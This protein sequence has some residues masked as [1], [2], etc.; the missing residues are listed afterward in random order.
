MRRGTRMRGPDDFGGFCRMKNRQGM[1]RAA[2]LVF[3]GAL[4]AA[5][6]AG[7]GARKAAAQTDTT[8]TAKV[9]RGDLS[10]TVHGT[11]ALAPTSVQAVS[12]DS[13]GKVTQIFKRNGD[14][15]KNGDAIAEVT[16][17]VTDEKKNITAPM[18]GVVALSQ[19]VVGTAVQAGM[20]VCQVQSTGS[21]ELTVG[22]DELDISGVKTGQKAD[23]KVDALPGKTFSGTVNRISQVGVAA[24]GVTTFDVTIGLSDSAGMLSNMSASA[25]IHTG[26]V[27]NVLLVPVE[28]LQKADNGYTLTVRTKENDKNKD[29]VTNVQAGLIGE[30]Q[31]EVTSGV[32]E[33]DVVVL[34]S[35]A[36][37][38]GTSINGINMGGRSGSSNAS[39]ASAAASAAA[40]SGGASS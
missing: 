14:T 9:T 8:R 12:S 33:G 15:V 13:T 29:T 10:V 37:T 22:I 31:A 34:P 6:L 38:N 25:D 39:G 1:W 30:T 40:S 2:A 32:S 18:D 36:P 4:C 28:A 19:L 20:T 21:F 16:V 23:V 27:T 11:G 5:L 17:P 35:L 24:N 26:D 3:A 7:C